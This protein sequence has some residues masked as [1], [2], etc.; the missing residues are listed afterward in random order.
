MGRFQD[1]ARN[2]DPLTLSPSL[3]PRSNHGIVAM[4]HFQN[5]VVG[6]G[7]AGSGLHTFLCET[8]GCP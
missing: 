6:Q 2:R 1:G 3:R 8:W 7:G 5:K 4:R